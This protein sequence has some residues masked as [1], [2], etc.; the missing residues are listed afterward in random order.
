M[1]ANKQDLPDAQST[2]KIIE[3][4]GLKELT[5]NPWRIQETCAVTGKGLYEGAEQMAEMLELNFKKQDLAEDRFTRSNFWI[6]L[7]SWHCFG[8]R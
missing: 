5:K 6:Q 7:C 1:F 4:L 8:S 3:S 2:D